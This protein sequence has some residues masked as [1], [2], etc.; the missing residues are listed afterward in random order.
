MAT[1]YND[2]IFAQE[3]FQ[4][5]TNLLTPFNLFAKDISPAAANKGDA[6]IV[7]L[8]G[9]TT[10]TTFSQSTT[11]YEQTGGTI[12]AV[13]V[14]LDK[15]D[16][17]P[18]DLTAQQLAESSAAGRYDQ[19]AAQMARSHAIRMNSHLFAAITTG[20]FGTAVSTAI[21]NYDRNIFPLARKALLDAGVRGKK[22]M[23]VNTEAES[24]FLSDNN[25]TLAL[26]RGMP[27]TMTEGEIGKVYG[28][29]VY[30]APELG[31]A[32]VSRTGFV[33]GENA[34][35]I[36]F[37]GLGEVL[38][39]EEYAAVEVMTDDESGFSMLY[40]RHWSRA[41]GKYFL[42]FHSLFGFANAVTNELKLLVQTD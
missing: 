36:A 1:V 15:R 23:V 30:S 18:V 22:S 6:V 3:A 28:F 41:Q 4:Q 12:S 13:T 9:N 19:W 10:T 25:L 38:P 11:A 31:Y 16:I 35:A 32:S 2:K 14:T 5:L 42:N 33:T 7:P 29:D 27:T 17:T 24:N 21:A 8:F 37:R 34:M 20:S 39:D 26:N 40:T